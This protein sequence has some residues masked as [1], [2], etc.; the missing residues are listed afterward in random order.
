MVEIGFVRAKFHFLWP[1]SLS[2]DLKEYHHLLYLWPWGF[3]VK[4]K[5]KD[6]CRKYPVVNYLESQTSS[7]YWDLI[8][9]FIQWKK[10]VP[11]TAYCL[12]HLFL[13]TVWNKS[14][15]N[16]EKHQCNYEFSYNKQLLLSKLL[17][18]VFKTTDFS[19]FQN[20][21]FCEFKQCPL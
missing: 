11:A 8:Y 5:E 19:A 3:S 16:Q 15:L 14:F 18:E 6:K 7:T 4:K 17:R 21:S 12:R 2:M 10:S 1:L 9:G 13:T 20:A